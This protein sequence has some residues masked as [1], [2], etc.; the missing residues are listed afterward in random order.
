MFGVTAIAAK[1]LSSEAVECVSPPKN[2]GL[3]VSVRVANNGV[4]FS[5][6][7]GVFLVTGALQ[8]KVDVGCQL[9]EFLHSCCVCL[10]VFIMNARY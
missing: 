4:D 3:E 1:W 6:S 10:S 7:Y 2:A 8:K 5:T 9:C